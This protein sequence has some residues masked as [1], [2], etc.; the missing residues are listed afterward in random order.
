MTP[1]LLC[2]N[3]G[4][5]S[6]LSCEKARMRRRGMLNSTFS[7]GHCNA[8]ADY[9]YHTAQDRNARRSSAKM[10]C[11]SGEGRISA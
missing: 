2:L 3:P 4:I 8:T 10:I 11:I 7:E 5:C 9:K 1:A 6:S